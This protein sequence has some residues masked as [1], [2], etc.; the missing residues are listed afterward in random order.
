MY[1]KRLL[2]ALNRAFHYH[3]SGSLELGESYDYTLGIHHYDKDLTSA[4]LE[5]MAAS[6]ATTIW[7]DIKN[8]ARSHHES[9]VHALYKSPSPDMNLGPEILPSESLSLPDTWVNMRIDE[10]D[11]VPFAQRLIVGINTARPH[12]STSPTYKQDISLVLSVA[13]HI[14]SSSPE[15]I[16]FAQHP[17]ARYIDSID[18]HS[19]GPSKTVFRIKGRIYSGVS[20]DASPKY[21]KFVMPESIAEA[22][23]G[24]PPRLPFSHHVTDSD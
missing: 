19:N 20:H 23:W 12:D 16:A 21:Y 2:G 7:N 13:L 8:A 17:D 3:S 1:R 14:T 18:K 22:N 11:L 15:H 9:L 6:I 5:D 24:S 10:D 4:K